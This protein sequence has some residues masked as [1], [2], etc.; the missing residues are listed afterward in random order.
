MGS[1]VAYESVSMA[2]SFSRAA[3]F[4]RLRK[5][6]D[7]AYVH[8]FW[9]N[10]VAGAVRQSVIATTLG[11]GDELASGAKLTDQVLLIWAFDEDEGGALSALAKR[12]GAPLLFG[13]VWEQLGID[14]VLADLLAERA[15]E[16]PV[17][18]AV[19]VFTLHQLFV[20]K[21]PT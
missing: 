4:F 20:C 8:I 5:S 16:F 12:L 10:R 6:G 1:W 2:L 3:M 13:K 11:R 17:E 21:H 18:R 15:F 7:R 14:E 9:N 19:L